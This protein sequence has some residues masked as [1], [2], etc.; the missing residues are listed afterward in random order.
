MNT[1]GERFK[2]IIEAEK[3]NEFSFS[4][5]IG[6][7]NTAIT[8]IVK[9][10]SKPGFEIIEAV[11]LEFPFLNSEWLINGSG[12]MKKETKQG[13]ERPDSYLQEYLH[14][15]EKQFV[16]L[17]E[18]FNSQIAVKDEQ[19]KAKDR[20]IEKLIDSLGKPNDVIEGAQVLPLWEENKATA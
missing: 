20:Q 14:T 18:M 19:I 11:L 9:G 8:K 5:R 15:L 6:K 3:L 1:I 10:E 17:K 4:K 7:S 12:D 2:M 16:E 13:T